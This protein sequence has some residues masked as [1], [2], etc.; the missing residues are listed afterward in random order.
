[1]KWQGSIANRIDE[2]HNFNKDG[3]IHEGDDITMYHWSDRT[4]YYVTKVIDQKH[5]FV[6]QYHVCL[7]KCFKEEG[8]DTVLTAVQAVPD[9]EWV[10]RYNHWYTVE[11]FDENTCKRMEARWSIDDRN[12]ENFYK[13]QLH[14]TDRQYKDHLKGKTIYKYNQLSSNI[15]F[16]VRDYYD[17]EF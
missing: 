12:R 11:T 3:L 5:I 16:G 17:W 8:I 13:Y 1:M 7:N 10:Y 2:G 6:Q 14:F 9:I 4:C 15:S